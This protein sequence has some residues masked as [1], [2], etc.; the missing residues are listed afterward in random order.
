M[1]RQA[2][3]RRKGVGLALASP[4]GGAFIADG[5]SRLRGRT[6]RG[7]F[8]SPMAGPSLRRDQPSDIGGGGRRLRLADRRGLHCGHQSVANSAAAHLIFA[9]SIVGAFIADSVPRLSAGPPPTSPRRSAGPSLR[10]PRR[11]GVGARES[12]H[13]ASPIGGAFH[14]AGRHPSGPAAHIA[15]A[16]VLVTTRRLPRLADRRGLH[17]AETPT[18]SAPLERQAS[19]P[20]GSAGPSLRMPT[21]PAGGLPPAP[22]ASRIGGAFIA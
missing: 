21:V 10:I 9:S 20:R 19:S 3:R 6:A 13:F 5:C 2:G 14:P 22:F 4:I 7:G 16:T 17:R 11:V 12:V 15:D 8:A 1:R 18:P